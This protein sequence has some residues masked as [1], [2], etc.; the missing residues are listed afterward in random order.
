MGKIKVLLAIR[1]RMLA[2]VVRHLVARQPDMAVASEVINLTEL[3][4]AIRTTKAEV[5]IITP[6]DADS[7]AGIGSYLLAAYPRLKIMVLSAKGDTAVLYESGS[8]EKHM[9]DVGEAAILGAI[10]EFKV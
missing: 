9:D 8:R 3:L 4:L 6:A 2:D 7:E 1:P 5:V 10:R